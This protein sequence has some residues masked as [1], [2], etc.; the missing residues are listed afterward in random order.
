M[1]CVNVSVSRPACHVRGLDYDILAPARVQSPA[2][3]SARLLRFYVRRRPSARRRLSAFAGEPKG[4]EEA[5]AD[6]DAP[7]IQDVTDKY[8]LPDPEST[9]VR[10]VCVTL[11]AVYH[12]GR[13]TRPNRH[14]Q[15]QV[16]AEQALRARR[17]L[18]RV[19]RLAIV[20]RRNTCVPDL[21]DPVLCVNTTQHMS[22]LCTSGVLPSGCVRPLVLH[23][24]SSACASR[25]TKAGGT[26]HVGAVHHRAWGAHC[27]RD[28]ARVASSDSR[29]SICIRVS[30]AVT[31]ACG[32][33]S[34]CVDVYRS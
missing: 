14:S 18:M 9:A 25:H 11:P 24:H 30:T 3:A 22:L 17:R 31:P 32:I 28:H 4:R 10:R 7:W 15:K 33:P 8:I 27:P 26:R 13:V 19:V 5:D 2:V 23:A 34:W 16:A 29:T 21:A 1:R 6:D 12:C 20:V